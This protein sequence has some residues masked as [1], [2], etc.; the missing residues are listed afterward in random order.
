MP[1]K[2]LVID[3]SVGCASDSRACRDFLNTILNKKYQVIM[4]EQLWG[5]WKRH[6]SRYAIF[7]MKAMTDKG[8]LLRRAIETNEDIRNKIRSSIEVKKDPTILLIVMK[9]MHLIETALVS[10]N[11]IISL[12]EQVRGHFKRA[13]FTAEELK[14]IVWVNPHKPA[15][16]AINWLKYG[17][18][19]DNYRML[20]YIDPDKVRLRSGHR[21]RQYAKEFKN[22]EKAN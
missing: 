18:R 9:D 17:A 3:A 16:K 12:D 22:Q 2:Q 20:G 5:E 11:T 6:E 13:S 8:R 19:P 4:S 1:P 7:W 15:E 14:I 21:P 10:D